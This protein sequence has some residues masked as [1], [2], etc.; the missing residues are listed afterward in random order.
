MDIAHKVGEMLVPYVVDENIA[1]TIHTHPT[2]IPTRRPIQREAVQVAEVVA[3]P[4][5]QSLA[6]PA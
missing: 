5:V 4:E 3:P 2:P 1:A 6:G